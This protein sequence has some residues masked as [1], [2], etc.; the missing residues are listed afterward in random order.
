[1]FIAESGVICHHVRQEEEM[2]RRAQLPPHT[3]LAQRHAPPALALP[4]EVDQSAGVLQV[5]EPVLRGLPHRR[6]HPRHQAGSLLVLLRRAADQLQLLPEA[7]VHLVH[8]AETGHQ[9]REA[10]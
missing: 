2:S 1:M 10:A 7:E 8:G 5:G 4:L 3:R 6:L 9:P